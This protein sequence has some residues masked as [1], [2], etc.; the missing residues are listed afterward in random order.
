MRREI[1]EY[2][3]RWILRPL[4][5]S[6]IIH[7]EW[8]SNDIEFSLDSPFRLIVDYTAELSPRSLAKTDPDRHPIT[9]WSKTDIERMLSTPIMSAVFFKTGDIRISF[10]NGWILFISA[11]TVEPSK[12]ITDDGLLWNGSEIANQMDY[13]VVAIDPW[14]GNRIEAPPWPSRPADLEINY[15]SD[16]IND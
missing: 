16:D 14:T 8:R 13:P 1:K 5:G 7:T 2:E 9:Y 11:G 12:L 6:R 3:D 10:R 4:R 15:D